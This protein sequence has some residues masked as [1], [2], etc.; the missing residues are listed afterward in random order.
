M[1]KVMILLSAICLIS[2]TS[3][4]EDAT[5][6][7][8]SGNVAEAAERDAKSNKLPVITFDKKEHDFGE[9]ISGTPQ[10]TV[11][12]YT[13]TGE[14]PL[15]IT[16]IKSTCGCTVPKDWSREPLAVGESDKFTVKFN[17]KGANKTSKVIN[18]TANTATGKES[19]KITAFIKP[20]PNA[21]K[22]AANTNLGPVTQ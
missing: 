10:E 9:I 2:L 16:D 4:K 19:V 17:G 15:V 21:P 3:C 18:I 22:P 6:K 5:A 8:N 12:T 7:I 14:A 11:F 1:K 13:N 20:D